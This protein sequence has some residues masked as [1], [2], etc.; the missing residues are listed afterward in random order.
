MGQRDCALG[1]DAELVIGRII[2][3]NVRVRKRPHPDG[4]DVKVVFGQIP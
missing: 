4:H 1:N 2:V 3:W